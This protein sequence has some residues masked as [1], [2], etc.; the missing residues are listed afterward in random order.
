MDH[1]S[2]NDVNTSFL[3]RNDNDELMKNQVK[4]LE[5][6]QDVQNTQKKI[7][8]QLARHEVQY[9]E[10]LNKLADY[11]VTTTR[12]NRADSVEERFSPLET[13]EELFQLEENLKNPEFRLKYFK[14][15]S[16]LCSPGLGAKGTNICYK[17]IDYFFSR[18]LLTLVSW[19]GNSRD[20]NEKVAFKFLTQTRQMFFSVLHNA[21]PNISQLETDNFIKTII[22]NS[23]QRFNATLKP[24][25]VS[26]LKNHTKR[27]NNA[28]AQNDA[29]ESSIEPTA[30]VDVQQPTANDDV[31]KN[32]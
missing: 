28:N 27:S 6:L 26:T 18:E 16:S 12:T 9:N 29:V 11:S 8:Q 14:I 23:K 1:I 31:Q 3:L 5:V 10:L 25:S 17:I 30:D 4:I 7:L 20:Q 21:D 19:S 24:L 2:L 13:V 32:N 15:M 22:K